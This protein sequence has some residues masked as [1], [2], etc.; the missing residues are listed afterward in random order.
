[1]SGPPVVFGGT[2]LIGRVIA[3]RLDGLPLGSGFDVRWTCDMQEALS[4]IEPLAVINAAWPKENHLE[5]FAN[6]MQ[7]CA[8]WWTSRQERGCLINIA[9]IYATLPPRFEMYPPGMGKDADYV[10]AKAGIVALTRYW[11]RRLRGTGIRVNAVSP[12]GVYRDEPQEFVD[13][14]SAQTNHGTM[15]PAQAVADAC[16]FLVGNEYVTGINLIVSDGFDL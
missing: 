16:A 8:S 5:G 1:M 12:G 13:A 4:R 6:V 2:G 10:A 9:S 14:Y 11:A 3:E 15:L 7:C